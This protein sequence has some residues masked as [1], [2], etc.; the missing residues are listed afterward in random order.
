MDEAEPLFWVDE[1]KYGC[2]QPVRVGDLLR[3]KDFGYGWK[4]EGKIVLV[5]G[6]VDPTY[7]RFVPEYPDDLFP[8]DEPE[9]CLVIIDG[10]RTTIRIEYLEAIVD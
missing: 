8:P 9:E 2:T 5:L 4:E 1:S 3:V 10:H 7:T 6:T